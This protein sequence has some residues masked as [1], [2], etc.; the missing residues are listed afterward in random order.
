MIFK[1]TKF[2][3]S[4]F[5]G[6]ILLEI[7]LCGSGQVL[8]IYGNFTLKMLNYVVML[9]IGLIFIIRYKSVNN[10][11]VVVSLI[12]TYLFF[13]G[14]MF[15]IINDGITNLYEDLSPLLYFYTIFY[16]YYT[17]KNEKI[18]ELVKK[19]VQFSSLLLA[20][21]Y[22]FYIILINVGFLSFPIVYAF[23][24]NTSDIMFRGENGEFFYK[25]F[26][27]LPIGLCFF[28]CNNKPFSIQSIILLLAIYF[29]KTRGFYIMTLL[30]YILYYIFKLRESHY[31]VKKIQLVFFFVSIILVA[32]SINTYYSSMFSDRESG[33][34]LRVDQFKQVFER[35][36]VMS[37]LFGHG[38]GIGI[39]ARE[40]HMENSYLEIFHKQGI[41]GLMF[42][43][44]L[45]ISSILNFNKIENS[46]KIKMLPFIL[47]IL[48]IYIQSIF[49]P[50]INN[51][52][53]M[54]FILISYV[55]IVNGKRIYEDKRLYSSI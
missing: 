1:P 16:F 55:I 45:L 25:G 24:E 10:S 53:G 46:Q 29:T 22:L 8:K 17:L 52:I 35:I 5:L 26:L 36:N 44:Y 49:N 38:F 9:A 13:V 51:P 43:F 28:I 32:Y 2:I 31:K 39:P 23:F 42:W 18:I 30:A 4:V 50:Y 33:T 40:I 14:T 27:Y 41:L 54:A 48:T 15:S 34:Q 11:V 7:F 37:V 12:Y 20:I 47:S 19:I 6:L 21:L 3:N